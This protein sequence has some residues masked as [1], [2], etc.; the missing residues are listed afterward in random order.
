[1][2]DYY[3][4]LGVGESASPAAIKKAYR[5]LAQKYHPDKNPDDPAADAKFKE[6]NE[7]NEILSDSN[8]RR[9]FDTARRGGFS[10][11]IGDLFESMFGG[12]PFSGMG[13]P[14]RQSRTNRRPA[15][16]GDAVVNIELS[17]DE[18][19]AGTAARSFN[20]KRHVTCETCTGQGGD[21]ISHCSRCGGSGQIVQEFQQGAMRFQTAMPCEA[22]HGAGEII[23]NP[24]PECR[25]R[26]TIA[27]HDAYDVTVTSMKS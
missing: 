25:G 20:I 22:C 17:L 13:S 3:T 11:G 5:K 24:C 27:R 4:I 1:M 23:T 8:K 16:P 6:I 9:Q 15:T 18:L 26:G 7:A 14:G 12:N 19:D 2:K 10:G 21:K